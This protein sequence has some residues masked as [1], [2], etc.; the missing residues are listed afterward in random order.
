MK[1]T[2]IR[3]TN[4]IVKL[5]ETKTV[6][7]GDPVTLYHGTYYFKGEVIFVGDTH[8]VIVDKEQG[9]AIKYTRD[10]V[11]EQNSYIKGCNLYKAKLAGE[12]EI[13]PITWKYEATITEE[14]EVTEKVGLVPGNTVR[15]IDG[16][17]MLIKFGEI[18]QYKNHNKAVVV[19]D[20][21]GQL[22]TGFLYSSTISKTDRK[23]EF[24]S[25]ASSSAMQ[26]YVNQ[27]EFE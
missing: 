21:N 14:V 12:Y 10:A 11:Y 15:L 16:R 1:L 17:N 27:L 26:V 23:M 22:F 25:D 19:G 8:L 3:K 24:I 6:K 13:D 4:E 9:E 2:Q 20:V 5:T 7:I 18:E